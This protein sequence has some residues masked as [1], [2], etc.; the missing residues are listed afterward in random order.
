MNFSD[1]NL[2]VENHGFRHGLSATGDASEEGGVSVLNHEGKCADA[3]P[4]DGGEGTVGGG[5]EG[6]DSGKGGVG[7]GRP[8]GSS[9]DELKL[10]I[11]DT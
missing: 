1:D 3:E 11:S 9:E 6:G 7:Y 8:I 4:V 10:S 2:V 5:R